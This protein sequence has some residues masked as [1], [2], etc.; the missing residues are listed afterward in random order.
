MSRGRLR[1]DK[2][3]KNFDNA[4][5]I[6]N[7]SQTI[8]PSELK[9][10]LMNKLSTSLILINITID[11]FDLLKQQ[12][13]PDHHVKREL[14]YI[15]KLIEFYIKHQNDEIQSNVNVNEYFKSL[16][17]TIVEKKYK[18]VDVTINVN[19]P[20]DV[21]KK[22]HENLKIEIQNFRGIR[23]YLVD[24]IQTIAKKFE[25]E[26]KND[27]K[28][29]TF[30][31][32]RTQP[33]EHT[34]ATQILTPSTIQN[35][36]QKE[37]KGEETYLLVSQL[38][39]LATSKKFGDKAI[40]KQ[41]WK[42][43]NE[44]MENT[45]Y[46][47]NTQGEFDVVSYK[48]ATQ[49]LNLHLIE[50]LKEKNSFI[51]KKFAKKLNNCEKLNN[52]LNNL[53]DILNN[54]NNKDY[55]AVISEYNEKLLALA[56]AVSGFD[57]FEKE[58]PF[59]GFHV[60]QID[61]LSKNE[62]K[63]ILKLLDS[64]HELLFKKILNP[65]MSSR[66]F[67]CL[68]GEDS[69]E[70][71]IKKMTLDWLEY[72]TK[73]SLHDYVRNRASSWKYIDRHKNTSDDQDTK[74]DRFNAVAGVLTNMVPKT[75][76]ESAG[77]HGNGEDKPHRFQ[78]LSCFKTINEKIYSIL[79]KAKWH[80]WMGGN[81]QSNLLHRLV[82]IRR[83]TYSAFYNLKNRFGICQNEFNALQQESN[84]SFNEELV[85]RLND[86]EN[87]TKGLN[88]FIPSVFARK[89]DD[90][91]RNAKTNGKSSISNK[92][93]KLLI[94]TIPDYSEIRDELIASLNKTTLPTEYVDL[95]ALLKQKIDQVGKTAKNSDFYNVIIKIQSDII[96]RL[97][98]A[99]DRF[100]QELQ[101][102]NHK[103]KM[104]FS[105][106]QLKEIRRSCY[107]EVQ[108][109]QLIDVMNTKINS[110]FDIESNDDNIKETENKQVTDGI[111]DLVI[112]NKLDSSKEKK[113]KDAYDRLANFIVTAKTLDQNIDPKIL[114]RYLYSRQQYE[115]IE[116]PLS[117]AIYFKVSDSL[118]N[119]IG[120]GKLAKTSYL[121]LQPCVEETALSAVKGLA[122]QLPYGADTVANIALDYCISEANKKHLDGIRAHGDLANEWGDI[123]MFA[124][125]LALLIAK[126]F[127]LYEETAGVELTLNDCNTIASTIATLLEKAL[128]K[129]N[130]ENKPYNSFREIISDIH[131]MKIKHGNFLF[132]KN[133]VEQPLSNGRSTE[134]VLQVSPFYVV[135]SDNTYTFYA[136]AGVDYTKYGFR[137]GSSDE[138]AKSGLSPI[139]TEFSIPQ[140]KFK[141]ALQTIQNYET[142][143]YE[144]SFKDTKVNLMDDFKQMM[145]FK[146][147]S[148]N[149]PSGEDVVPLNVAQLN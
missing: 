22:I 114:H 25:K 124:D 136:P 14:E 48:E 132:F 37:P 85:I 76:T 110:G 127:V 77:E 53:I 141:S 105:L 59:T 9:K 147:D 34:F 94:K 56:C 36:L 100:I 111:D 39:G 18:K 72:K 118:R 4:D 83:K 66:L 11:D 1:K 67:Y 140:T 98:I 89:S 49:L 104:N 73:R 52:D 95:I 6:V 5:E 93:N 62:R 63:E 133:V 119:L 74:G 44:I 128:N 139:H 12:I 26:S 8:S 42:I 149:L 146:S 41:L 126:E 121:A 16:L 61:G 145:N 46:F 50:D 29:F 87:R 32:Q 99:E 57:S 106:D 122:K 19:D 115:I 101:V 75:S 142:S 21:L 60:E 116:R 7:L 103:Y 144:V 125:A 43:I 23:P 27:G 54:E 80:S 84:K 31:R 129:A 40:K 2:E 33:Q 45:N 10:L 120:L 24:N 81:Q 148:Q 38:H 97:V 35:F 92:L 3:N 96:D 70:V 64:Q 30:G 123:D 109:Q 13:S 17:K 135:D 137:K 102:K 107:S 69:T 20:L 117:K 82:Q 138:V 113:I 65:N 79:D 51:Q 90:Q 86:Y 78:L 112:L 88:K 28:L 58:L 130:K 68:K 134:G 108:K 55:L 47:N 15:G 131:L 143:L 71:N 91:I